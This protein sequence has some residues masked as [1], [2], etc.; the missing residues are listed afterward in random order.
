MKI[1]WLPH[2]AGFGLLCCAKSR[3]PGV[4]ESVSLIATW[5]TVS[6]PQLPAPASRQCSCV[7]L[8]VRCALPRGISPS[9][10]DIRRRV[11]PCLCRRRL[12]PRAIRWPSLA[13]QGVSQPY[14]GAGSIPA[15]RARV[16]RAPQRPISRLRLF[17]PATCPEAPGLWY[18]WLRGHK[19]PQYPHWSAGCSRRTRTCR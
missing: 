19:G 11:L 8:Q 4:T 14:R 15:R 17:R 9:D 5:T 16:G 3:Q 10:Q 2:P 6:P 12:I 1:G 13:A 18:Q 7:R